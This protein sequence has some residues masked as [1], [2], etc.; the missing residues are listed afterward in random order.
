VVEGIH[1][2]WEKRYMEKDA[3]MLEGGIHFG[4]RDK[5]GGSKAHMLERVHTV[6]QAYT[7]KE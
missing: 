1:T 4:E 6:G 5:Y 2:C 7:G 3:Y